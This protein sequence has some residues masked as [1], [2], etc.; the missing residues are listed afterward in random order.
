[1]SYE[2]QYAETIPLL[3]EPVVDGLRN[4]EFRIGQKEDPEERRFYYG[5]V[6]ETMPLDELCGRVLKIDA[7]L[8]IAESPDLPRNDERLILRNGLGFIG[9]ADL[10]SHKVFEE[11]SF[12]GLVL[13]F[14]NPQ[15]VQVDLSESIDVPDKADGQTFRITRVHASLFHMRSCKPIAGFDWPP[16]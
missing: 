12:D 8:A 6:I 9:E 14:L 2:D 16:A 5:R 11:V 13:T 7:G 10:P 3:G 4:L 15:I 1:M